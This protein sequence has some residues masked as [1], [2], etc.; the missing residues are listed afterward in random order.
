[1]YLITVTNMALLDHSGPFL[2]GI[3]NGLNLGSHGGFRSWYETREH[4][5]S[6]VNI[7]ID[8]RIS[9]AAEN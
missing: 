5:A 2:Y 6:T 3:E 7:C 1:M 9:M 8:S 4:L